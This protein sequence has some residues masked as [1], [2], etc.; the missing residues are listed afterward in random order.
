MKLL[1]IISTTDAPYVSIMKGLLPNCNIAVITKS[2][3]TVF[4]L[5]PLIEKHKF[6]GVLVSDVEFLKKLSGE[7]EATIGNFAGSYYTKFDTPFVIINP[8]AH[9]FS[10]PE[11]KFLFQRYASKITEPKKWKDIPQISW[12]IYKPENDARLYEM[13]KQS[14]MMAVDIETSGLNI[15]CT[16]YCFLLKHPSGKVFAHSVV[17]PMKDMDHYRFIKKVNA[18]MVPK[19]FQNGSYD[20]TYFIRWGVPVNAWYFDTYHMMHSLFAELPKD[21]GFLSAFFIKDFR[22]WKHEAQSVNLEDKY[23]YNAKDTWTTLFIMLAMLMGNLPKWAWDNYTEHEF[24]MVFPCISC[25]LEGLKVDE[26]ERLRLRKHYSDKA[27]SAKRRL[28]VITGVEN[29]NPGSP[30]QVLKLMQALGGKDFKKSDKKSMQKFKEKHSLNEFVAGLIKEYRESSKAVS[31]YIDIEMFE[32]RMLYSLDPGGTE[33]GRLAA[34]ASN[35]GRLD[36]KG[37]WVHYGTQIQNIPAY[38]K[39]MFVADDGFLLA[40]LDNSQSESRCTAYMSEDANLIKTVE[41]PLDF[42]KVNCTLFFGLKYEEI[43]KAIRDLG[44]RVN[45]GSSYNMG[46]EVLIDTMGLR[47]IL[48]AKQLLKLP[49][50]YTPR[51]VAEYL[52]ERFRVAYP[53]VKGKYYDEVCHEI[54]ATNKLVGPTG[55][56]RYCFSDPKKSK[57]SLNSYVAHGP[58]SLSVMIINEGFFDVWYQYQICENVIRFKAQIHDSLFIQYKPENE[59]VLDKISERMAKPV[60]VRGRS[61][62]IPNDRGYGKTRWSDLK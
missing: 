6:D 35:L 25:G 37:K 26:E 39:S 13:A 1:A 12:E 8:L 20:N 29:F 47:N 48:V 57:L 31:T 45:H 15:Y 36:E 43:T 56:T 2:P 62:S 58:Q 60:M 42:H 61:M 46:P 16:G 3:T 54:A 55:W 52:L 32:G 28:E 4:E 30:D 34:K 53:D 7:E 22:Y 59:W 40:E 14:I 5:K 17:V 9:F 11:S 24:K 21:L 41:S 18:L 23:F 38:A 33:T 27:I 49:V 10:V 19:V 50:R 51:Q 44:K